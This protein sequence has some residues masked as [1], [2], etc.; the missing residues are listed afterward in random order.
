M[1]RDQNYLEC[2]D[3]LRFS[4]LD[5][6]CEN[7]LGFFREIF[8]YIELFPAE[9]SVLNKDLDLANLL[10]AVYGRNFNAIFKQVF[11]IHLTNS[12]GFELSQQ[13][14]FKLNIPKR[15]WAFRF[16]DSRLEFYLENDLV[17]IEKCNESKL[18]LNRT[19]NYFTQFVNIQY[20]NIKSSQSVCPFVFQQA[21]L[22]SLTMSG[23]V[24][25]FDS[26]NYSNLNRLNST[27]KQ[28][29][30]IYTLNLNLNSQIFHQKVFQFT[31]SMAISGSLRRIEVD[32]FRAVTL[33]DLNYLGFQI[34]NTKGFLH[35]Q[36][37]E[38]IKSIGLS[39]L[40]GLGLSV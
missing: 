9:K 22:N 27:I 2:S 40:S 10:A 39:C 16:L 6:K 37:I 15:E 31:Q 7:I 23:D 35:S 14:K 13:S 38:W 32:L 1:R 30:I 4:D 18:W 5:L 11:Y 29:F 24:F 3:F 12:N 36:G 8:Y 25:R 34:R 17:Q 20:K 21:Q 28:F 33:T 19:E 26:T